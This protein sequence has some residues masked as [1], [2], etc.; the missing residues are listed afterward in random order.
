MKNLYGLLLIFAI[1]AV[2]SC[3][4]GDGYTY[5]EIETTQGTMKVKLFNSTPQHRDNFIKLANEGFYEDLLFHR[6]I[7]GFMLQGGDP[8]SRDGRLIPPQETFL[9]EPKVLSI[10]RDMHRLFEWFVQ[11]ILPQDPPKI[12]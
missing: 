12:G 11:L 9:L 2:T 5:A 4:Q 6:V 1:A 7:K 3:N 10:E 8:E